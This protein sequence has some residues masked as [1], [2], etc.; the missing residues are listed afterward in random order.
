MI[1]KPSKS[2]WNGFVP[3]LDHNDLVFACTRILD[4]DFLFLSS[5]GFNGF[6]ELVR[7]NSNTDEEPDHQESVE[8]T[9][10]ETIATTEVIKGSPDWNKQ[11]ISTV[12]TLRDATGLCRFFWCFFT[13]VSS[14][15]SAVS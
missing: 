7:D 15:P 4:C 12:D 1:P 13:A 8:D 9:T 14:A 3:Y 5:D 2:S 10:A 11:T 6:H